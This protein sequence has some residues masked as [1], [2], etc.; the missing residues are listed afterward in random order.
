MQGFVDCI[1][2]YFIHKKIQMFKC[3][4][5][6]KKKKKGNLETDGSNMAQKK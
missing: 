3:T 2:L 6:R 5:L 4:I 1:N